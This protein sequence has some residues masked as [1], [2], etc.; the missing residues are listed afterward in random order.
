MCSWIG[1]KLT[2]NFEVQWLVAMAETIH[3]PIPR[4]M[5][6]SDSWASLSAPT[7]GLGAD[8]PNFLELGR[9]PNHLGCVGFVGVQIC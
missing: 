2:Q 5:D 8:H 1:K 7:C 6:E 9:I 3:R 4:R